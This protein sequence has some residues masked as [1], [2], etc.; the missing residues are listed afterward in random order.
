MH[1]AANQHLVTLLKINFPRRKKTDPEDGFDV[2][3]TLSQGSDMLDKL[4]RRDLKKAMKSAAGP[5]KSWGFAM[6]FLEHLHSAGGH[7]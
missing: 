1:E 2:R 5:S 4:R 6:A 3:S 7:S